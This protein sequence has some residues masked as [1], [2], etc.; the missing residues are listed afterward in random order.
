MDNSRDRVP[1]HL[2]YNREKTKN[3][4]TMFGFKTIR[5]GRLDE[6]QEKVRSLEAEVK[7]YY[8]N[9]GAVNDY[10]K[11]IAPLLQ[12]FSVRGGF[13][14]VTRD[15]IQRCYEG[16]AP[17]YGIINKI[18]KAVGEV[19][20]YLELRERETGKYVEYHPV[21]ALLARPNDR[22][23]TVRYGRAWATNYLAY[24]DA[25]SYCPPVRIGKDL[26]QRNE[27]YLIPGFRVIGDKGGYD[28]PFKGIK[29]D[30]TGRTQKTIGP[31][32]YFESFNYNLDDTSIFGTSPLVVAAL[33]LSI[34]DRGMR[35]QDRSLENGGPS[36]LITPKPDNLGVLPKSADDLTRELNGESVKG[37]IKALRTAIELHELGSSP[38]DLGIL[39]SHKEAV[40]ALCFIYDLPV[41]LYYGQAKYENAKEA[42]KTLYESNAIPLANEF[43]ADLL[44]YLGLAGEYTLCVNTDRIDVLKEEPTD[45]LTNLEKMHATLN[46]MREA[47]GYEPRPE[48]WADLPIM[49]MG[50]MFGNESVDID[51]TEPVVNGEES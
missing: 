13:A 47:Y 34:I 38:V 40:N 28:R 7:G 3:E 45:V 16:C 18:A 39:S 23:N 24:G 17:A 26:G 42:K 30:G 5:A 22:Y 49:G 31:E 25:F 2:G 20:P 36:A 35:R 1:G 4:T 19:F 8:E 12:G 15:S 44:N 29:I 6:L 41:D 50:S 37:Q 46:E 10:F 32:D 51:E 14:S 33:Y 48:P 11:A 43:G 27:M 21:M 9:T